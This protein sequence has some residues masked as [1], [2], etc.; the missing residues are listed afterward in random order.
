MNLRKFTSPRQRRDSGKMVSEI[1]GFAI[2]IF[3]IAYAIYSVFTIEYQRAELKARFNF[4]GHPVSENQPQVDLHTLLQPTP[5]LIAQGHQIFETNCSPCHGPDGYGNGP[6]GAGLNPPP[7]NFHGTYFH[8]GTSVLTLY[9]TVTNGSPGTSMPSFDGSLSPEERMA[10]VHFIRTWIQNPAEDTPAQIAALPS[11]GA[12]SSGPTKLPPV[13]EPPQGPRIPIEL[14]LQLSAQPAPAPPTPAS[15][16]QGNFGQGAAIY[17]T[18]CASC[19]GP[20]GNGGKPLMQIASDPYVE[21]R[22][23]AFSQPL[24]PGWSSNA[25][26][27]SALVTHGLPGRMMPGFGTLTRPQMDALY[28]YVRQLAGLPAGA[29][30]KAA[31][32]NNGGAQ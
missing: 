30:S 9:H 13:K 1:I 26:A 4:T 32:A 6:Q 16:P 5:A 11:G 24:N 31:S 19:H 8:Y 12:A 22:A 23:A 29:P 3:L 18:R 17:Q 28:A 2:V 15:I 25:Q 14:A 10:V 21:V 7:R 20:D 27:F